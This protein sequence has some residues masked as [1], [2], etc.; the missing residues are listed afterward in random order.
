[1]EEFERYIH[2]ARL[3]E[4]HLNSLS[5]FVITLYKGSTSKEV[6]FADLSCVS[7]NSFMTRLCKW[8]YLD[9]FG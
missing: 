5:G 7:D 4:T 2:L 3:R 1:M 9:V 6:I 8:R